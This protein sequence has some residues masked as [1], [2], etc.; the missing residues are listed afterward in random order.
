ME[1][2]RSN[3]GDFFRLVFR[4]NEPF[5]ALSQC[6]FVDFDHRDF[7]FDVYDFRTL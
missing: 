5:D 2:R 1:H 7:T 4:N 3:V 6:D